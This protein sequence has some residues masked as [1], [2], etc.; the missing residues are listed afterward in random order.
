MD[1]IIKIV[2]P[3]DVKSIID[4]IK[5]LKIQGATNVA[6]S[7]VKAMKL[8]LEHYMEDIHDDKKTFIKKLKKA[9]TIIAWARPNEP[10]AKNCIKFVIYKLTTGMLGETDIEKMVSLA[11]EKMD[12]YL[13]LIK[14]T[15]SQ[16][17]G[18]GTKL[19]KK[20]NELLT[21]CHS[22]TTEKMLIEISRQ[23]KGDLKVISCETR[24]RY[25]GRITARNL[26]NAGVETY[27]IVDSAV[28]SFLVDNKYLPVDAV[29]LGAD[30]INTDG[31][32]I[33]KVGSLNIAVSAS[34]S[35]RPIYVA[36]QLLKIDVTTYYDPINIE[37]RDAREVW[38][39]APEGL[40]II[41]PAFDR[42]PDELI[43][44]I[45]TEFG[46][47][48]PKDVYSMATEKYGWLM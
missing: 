38:S 29:L 20:H 14:D 36:A 43:K 40:N 27:L 30:Q 12:E 2:L 19:L 5:D 22:S 13:E 26:F 16:I 8:W 6:M 47:I 25:Q 10:L 4:D 31:S 1:G 45:I 33:N 15:K 24:P 23:R 35:G 7:S 39:D 48:K 44:G 21:H 42:I 11:E 41:N 18:H 34:L 9:G 32:V 17:I 46:V 28:S 3:S 37:L